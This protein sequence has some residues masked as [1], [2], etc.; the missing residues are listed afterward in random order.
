LFSALGVAFNPGC[1]FTGTSTHSFSF[2]MNVLELLTRA[3]SASGKKIEYK[4]GKGGMKPN[5]DLPD[6]GSAGQCDCSGFVAWCLG[7]SRQTENPFYLNANGGWIETTAV[8]KDILSNTG[9]FSQCEAQPG[10]I[11][12]YG[13]SHSGQGH[14]GIVVSVTISGGKKVAS[15]VIHCSSGNWKKNGDAILETVAT[16]FTS[17]ANSVYGWYEGISKGTLE[18][19]QLIEIG[20]A[21]PVIEP[22]AGKWPTPVVLQQ[23]GAKAGFVNVWG[24][25]DET[26]RFCQAG[27][28]INADGA[29]N[30]YHPAGKGIDNLLNAGEPPKGKPNA[31]HELWKWWGIVTKDGVP[32]VQT[33]GEW[34][35]YYIS[36]TAL[37]NPGQAETSIARYVDSNKIPFVVLPNVDKARIMLGDMA[38]VVNRANGKSSAAIVADL[39]PTDQLGEGSIELARRL[40]VD[41]D[42]KK[43]GTSEEDILYI[44][45][46]GSGNR[47][48]QSLAKIEELAKNHFDAWGGEARVEALPKLV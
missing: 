2:F 46:A 1:Y 40:G 19:M 36:T 42:P 4:L 6:A 44:V 45:F 37:T 10:C 23:Y 28:T 34:A 14:I 12:V 38:W 41:P 5:A 24:C 39:G 27:M 15:R 33:T 9:L 32:V 22:L 47:K 17:N 43:G 7:I 35:G 8:H 29:P 13:D 25:A 18:A 21:I 20:R 30:A 31:S 26:A 3:R 48:G 11:V 16:V